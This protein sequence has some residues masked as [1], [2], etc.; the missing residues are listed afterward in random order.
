MLA[1]IGIDGMCVTNASVE[2]NI[3]CG[4]EGNSI[5]KLN[6]FSRKQSE[7]TLLSKV[8]AIIDEEEENKNE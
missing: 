2:E 5:A 4:D 1:D 8:G 7:E 3:R 6:I